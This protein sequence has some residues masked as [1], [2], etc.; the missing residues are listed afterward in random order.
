[1]DM[2]HQDLVFYMN[3]LSDD[4]MPDVGIGAEISNSELRDLYDVTLP[5]I[6]K[7][8]DECRRTLSNYMSKG[9][10]DRDL[11]SEARQRC[12]DASNWTSE[13]IF[14]HRRNKLHLDKNTKHREITF[15]KFVPGGGVS[16]YQFLTSFGNWADDYLSEEA[17]ADQLYHRYLDKSITESYAELNSMKES[18]PAM[19]NWLIQ[20][21][22][23]AVPIAHDCIKSIQRMPTPNQSD[24]S[25]SAQYLRSIHKLL[26]SLSELEIAK[27]SAGPQATELPGKQR[28]LVCID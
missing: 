26:T 4:L 24:I 14:R 12:E 8:V 15:T 22:G 20:K 1:M 2:M 10:Y 23:S 27:G 7:V 9:N 21:Y 25:G 17:K 11:A 19:K 28:I 6:S 3:R 13:L 16:I 18:F 5:Q